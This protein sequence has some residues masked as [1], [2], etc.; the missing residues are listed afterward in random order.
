[1][2]QWPEHSIQ[3]YLTRLPTY[4]LELVF[5]SQ[6]CP[7]PNSVLQPEDYARIL[8]IL[9]TRPDSQYFCRNIQEP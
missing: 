4:K 1:M 8:Q 2:E 9:H 6:R 3:A 7:N 5:D